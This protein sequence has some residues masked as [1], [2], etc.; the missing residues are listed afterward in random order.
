MAGNLVSSLI[1]AAKTNWLN[2]NKFTETKEYGKEFEDK[3]SY[4]RYFLG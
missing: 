2:K 1:S 4:S 3:S